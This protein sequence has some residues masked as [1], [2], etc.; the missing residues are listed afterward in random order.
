MKETTRFRRFSGGDNLVFSLI[1]LILIGVLIFLYNKIAFIFYPLIVV[2]SSVLAPVI[3]AIVMYYLFNPLV[4][5]LEKHKI[6][7]IW[8][9]I[10]LY[11]AVIALLTG[12]IVLIV[13]VIQVQVTSFVE[14]FP[15]YVDTL[16]NKFNQWSAYSI[17]EPTI[18]SATKW[19]YEFIRDVP[20]NIV[21]NLSTT[22]DGISNV[23]SSV[24]KVVITLV[25]FPIFLFF[26][27]K[28]DKKF[29]HYAI[30]IVPPKFRS[31]FI[32]VFTNINEQVASY[33]KGQLIVSI[34][35]GFLMYIGFVI[36][37]LNH[38]VIIAL[39]AAVTCIVPYIGPAIAFIPA[40]IIAVIHSPFM[41]F[42]LL[43][44]WIVVQTLEGQ[45]VS[46]NIMGKSLNIHPLTIII[47]L[48]VMGELLGVVGLIFGIPIYAI[49]KVLVSFIFQK[50]KMR[51]NQYYGEDA[52]EY[53]IQTF[54][55]D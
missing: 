22:A 32:I 44:V 14:D 24:S 52:G 38:A 8:G 31:D 12:L 35:I 7:R 49:I 42:K 28:D 43:V 45:F 27:L 46:P 39:V 18:N 48:L 13:P 16:S 33:I 30:K 19:F 26:L 9:I 21:D 41:L 15:G 50:I 54:E 17:F 55:K 2:L 36:I 11:L 34:C 20:G 5:W 23:V 6:K 10:L 51:Y 29:I 40:L 25:I 47:V 37:G 53:E 1:V 4:N 3:I